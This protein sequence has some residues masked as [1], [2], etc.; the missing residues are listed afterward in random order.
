MTQDEIR[1]IAYKISLRFFP[2]AADSGR[3]WKL[4]EAITDAFKEQAP[5]R[6]QRSRSARGAQGQTQGQTELA[7]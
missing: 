4:T 6:P 2:S 7:S 5:D 1:D 3:K